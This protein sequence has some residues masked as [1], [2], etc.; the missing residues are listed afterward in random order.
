M[1]GVQM[2]A[3][4]ADERYGYAGGKGAPVWEAEL[5]DL[6]SKFVLSHMQGRRNE[7]LI[8]H[9]LT[10]GAS[11]LCNRHDLVPLTDG[12]GNQAL[13]T[14]GGEQRM[15]FKNGGTAPE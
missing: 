14:A 10:D 6:A 13:E 3:L 4:E 11:R 7:E 15:L 2:Q 9:L 5:I 12:A 1:H 8:R